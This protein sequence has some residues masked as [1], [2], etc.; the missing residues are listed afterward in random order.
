MND[1]IYKIKI[2]LNY[3]T[4]DKEKR[5]YVLLD[6]TKD[7]DIKYDLKKILNKN[8]YDTIYNETKVLEKNKNLDTTMMIVNLKKK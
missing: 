8:I 5:D 6:P 7:K 3:K 4:S 1:N 2:V